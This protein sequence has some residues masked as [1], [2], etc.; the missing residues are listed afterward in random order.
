MLRLTGLGSL[1]AVA[2][3]FVL[4]APGT[5]P[6]MS[7]EAKMAR[8]ITVSATGRVS[9]EPDIVRIQAGLTTEADTAR[10]ALTENNQVMEKL[11]DSLEDKGIAEADIQTAN[12]HVSP[13][14][15]RPDRGGTARIDGYQVSNQVE[16]TVRKVDDAGEIL[17][18]LVALGANQLNGISFEV[19]NADELKDAAREK[20]I[21]A[22]RRRAELLASAADAKVGSV[23]AIAE[24][25]PI[26]GPRPMAMRRTRM[27]EAS[28]VPIAAGSQE[29]IARVTVTWGLE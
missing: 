24:G 21:A 13:R 10:R 4:S 8:T 7:E 16:V 9:A 3:A 22:A 12:F 27:A 19:S 28:A 6:A 11:L 20:A 25:A 18:T 15:T 23:I 26:E 5:T 29:L 17:D 1:L 2:L 14:Y